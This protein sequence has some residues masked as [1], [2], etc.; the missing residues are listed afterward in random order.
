M[1]KMPTD[2]GPKVPKKG[3][4]GVKNGFNGKGT[5][6]HD[7]PEKLFTP[8]I[9]LYN[10]PDNMEYEENATIMWRRSRQQSYAY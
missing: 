4:E 10:D 1:D 2:S 3:T 6:K 5:E 9:N 8:E 7:L